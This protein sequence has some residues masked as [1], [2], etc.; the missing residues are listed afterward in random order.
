MAHVCTAVKTAT[1]L[2]FNGVRGQM[3]PNSSCNSFAHWPTADLDEAVHG[4]EGPSPAYLGWDPKSNTLLSIVY[5]SNRACNG[6]IA[7]TG[8]GIY[9][10]CFS[11]PDRAMTVQRL[12]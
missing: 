2:F 6:L 10:L 3:G 12:I 1:P 7:A 4:S 9:L 11:P 5:S 8:E